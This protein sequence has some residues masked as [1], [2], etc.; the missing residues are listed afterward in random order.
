MSYLTLVAKVAVEPAAQTVLLDAML[1]A[2]KVYNGLIYALRQEYE[3]TGKSKVSQQNLNKILKTLPRAK[4]YYSLSVQAT[5]DEVLRA[6]QSYFALK[7]AGHE[8]AHPPGFRRKNSY[9]GLRYYDGYGVTLIGNQ[10]TLS[11]GLSRLDGARQVTIQIQYRTDVVFRRV[12]NVLLTY[13]TV[14]GM[15]AHLVVEVEDGQAKGTRKVAVDLGETQAISA[16]FDDGTNLLYSGREIKAIRRYW[17]KVRTKVKPPTVE[18]RKKSRRYRQIERKES[19]QVNHLLH[20][21][22]KDF[23]ERCDQ[24]GVDTIAI[25]ELTGI[26]ENIDYGERL[27][28]RLHAWPFAKLTNMITYKAKR[29]GIQVVP[30]SES[31]SSQTCHACHKVAKS[32]RKTRGSYA[33]ACGW[34]AHADVNAS[35]NLFQSAF[36]VSPL[37]GSSGDVDAP[38]VVS[39]ITRRHMVCKA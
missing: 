8:T 38:A 6:Y 37:I 25:G 9:S 1:C 19:R 27:N 14:H 15:E 22:S 17:Q 39:L 30:I 20:L 33:C 3:Q 28:Q 10:L 26:R 11:L 31:F 29:Q 2:T 35:A 13:D 21:I 16:M 34:H 5:R 18:H 4:A 24:A 12:V 7:K 32:N 23:V 36:Q